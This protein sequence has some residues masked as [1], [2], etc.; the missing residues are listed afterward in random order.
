MIRRMIPGLSLVC[1][2]L[3]APPASATDGS[4]SLRLVSCS[5]FER[6]R[7]KLT[8]FQTN[9]SEKALEFNLPDESVLEQERDWV[10]VDATVDCG[11][12]AQCE[13]FGRGQ[14]RILRVSHGW[15]GGLK[16]ISGKFVV[17]F[18]DG[19]KIEGNFTAKYVKPSPPRICE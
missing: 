2:S 6:Y 4:G 8:G 5:F 11:D 12:P 17:A 7:L 1:L 3:L 14:I 9:G 16:S 13:L 18:R 19:R 15:R 10:E